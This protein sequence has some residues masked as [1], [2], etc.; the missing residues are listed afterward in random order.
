MRSLGWTLLYPTGVLAEEEKSGHVDRHA[1]R[2][3]GVK[4][5][6][7]TP[8]GGRG[9][10]YLKQAETKHFLICLIIRLSTVHMISVLTEI[11]GFCV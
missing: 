11:S 3:G 7:R 1:Q 9:V 5:H 8:D 6:R 2:E 10:M 4:R